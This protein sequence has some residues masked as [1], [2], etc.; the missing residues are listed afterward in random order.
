MDLSGLKWP[1]IIVLLVGGGWLFTSGGVNWLVAQSTKATPGV[2]AAR[3]V[4][5]EAMLSRVGGYSMRL[6]KYEQALECFQLAI[7]RYGEGGKNYWYNTYRQVRCYERIGNP[8]TAV[9]ILTY[10]IDNAASTHDPRVPENDNLG[11]IR[12]K[13]NETFELGETQ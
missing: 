13:L 1:L 10:L 5:D 3:D 4:R 12:N 2:D 7:D 6:W 8:Q 9:Q 11:L